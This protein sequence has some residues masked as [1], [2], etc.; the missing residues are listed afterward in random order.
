MNASTISET[1]RPAVEQLS[2]GRASLLQ[3]A[4]GLPTLMAY[5]VFAA[6]LVPRGWPNVVALMLAILVAEVPVSWAIM[7]RQV[8][9]ET[10]G[11]F[12]LLHAFP[13][14]RRVQLWVYLLVGLPL[15]LFSMIMIAGGGASVDQALLAGPFNWV[16][17]WFAMRPDPEMFTVLPR[18]RL[19]VVWALMPVS[20]VLVGGVT[21]ELYSRGFLLPRMEAMGAAAPALN[22]ALFA[23]FHL[24]APY[25]WPTFFLMTLP[26]AY[27]VWWRRSVR[28]GLFI[29]IGMLFLQWLML[30]ALVFGVV[31]PPT[32]S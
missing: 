25:S 24:V 32:V 26:W 27:A 20:F 4:P 12:A 28:I 9:K 30:T 7:V 2:L 8:R 17:E 31:P 19:L 22:A 15:V 21:Q 5:A 23:V 18:G 3:V 13:W 29:H 10:G 11:R 14:R 1:E 16:P 6:L